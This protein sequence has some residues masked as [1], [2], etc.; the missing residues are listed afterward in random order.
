MLRISQSSW[1]ESVINISTLSGLFEI[2][3]EVHI[4][5]RGESSHRNAQQTSFAPLPSVQASSCNGLPLSGHRPYV[6]CSHLMSAKVEI[7]REGLDLFM[8][9]LE[10]QALENVR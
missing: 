7:V 6:V 8:W 1:I 3:G 4:L 9:E 5:S 2:S 10:A